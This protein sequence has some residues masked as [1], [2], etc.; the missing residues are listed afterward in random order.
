MDIKFHLMKQLLLVAGLLAIHSLSAQH[1]F[2]NWYFG[3][4]AGVSFVSGSPVNLSGGQISTIE[5]CSSIS[6]GAGNLLF[7]TDGLVVY[8]KN[9]NF[10]PNGTGLLGDL[11]STQSALIV[12]DPGNANQYYI[13]TTDNYWGNDGLRY[14]IVDMTL[15][16]GN[17]DI[18][19]VKNIQLLNTCD[20]KLT[21]IQNSAGNGFWIVSHGPSNTS[22]SYY[23]YP[24]TAAGVGAPVVSSVGPMFSSGASYIGCMKISPAGNYI[25]R[26][27]YNEYAGEIAEFDITTGVVSNPSTYI[28][29]AQDYMYGVE[30]SAN[31]NVLYM[32]SGDYT[33][34][35]LF[36]FDM[37]A[38]TTAAIAA[39]G[40]VLDAD[41]SQLSGAIQIASNN[42]IYVSHPGTQSLGI[43]ND[44]DVLGLGCN[45]VRNGFA[46]NATTT[47]GLPN[48]LSNNVIAGIIPT[49]FRG[50]C[51]NYYPVP[52][53]NYLNIHSDVFNGNSIEFSAYNMLGEE[54]I[55]P[56]SIIPDKDKTGQADVSEL[57]GGMYCIKIITG[58]SILYGRFLK[59]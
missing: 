58:D 54:V 35:K 15:N 4:N 57:A 11:S 29:P 3:T 23:A 34:S 32:M 47:I 7:Y 21:G 36:Q 46:L 26:A 5:G 27:M 14:S 59:K 53:Y 42:K 33:P 49:L 39:T 44:P 48:A 8:N 38:G 17:G 24:L 41:N 10:M 6:D 13:F 28:A 19:A 40:T 50:D 56:T 16:G 31:G 2:D 55:T 22:N 45:Y 20:E 37:T 25:A 18:G 12:S 1:E 51:V 43:I 9:H 52:A 30:F